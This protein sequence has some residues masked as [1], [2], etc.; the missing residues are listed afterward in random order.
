MFEMAAGGLVE[1]AAQFNVGDALGRR[2]EKIVAA[3]GFKTHGGMRSGLRQL[4]RDT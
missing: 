4:M 1:L 3:L 2:L